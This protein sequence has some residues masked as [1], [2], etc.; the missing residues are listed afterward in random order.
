VLFEN[1]FKLLNGIN[2]HVYHSNDQSSLDLHSLSPIFLPIILLG[3]RPVHWHG[4]SQSQ[5][6]VNNSLH[7][8]IFQTIILQLLYVQST[9]RHFVSQLFSL[10]CQ[11]P[12]QTSLATN[13]IIYLLLNCSSL[14]DSCISQATSLLSLPHHLKYGCWCVHSSIHS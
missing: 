5:P 8:G 12:Y 6:Y 13:T 4:Y 3:H 7:H 11:A 2:A 9:F 1:L 10:F 14:V